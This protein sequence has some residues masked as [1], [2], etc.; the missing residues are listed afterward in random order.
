MAKALICD[1]CK[2][3]ITRYGQMNT[4]K[5]MPYIGIEAVNQSNSKSVDLCNECTK[6]LMQYINNE[7]EMVIFN[8]RRAEDDKTEHSDPGI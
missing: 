6:T 5:I 2:A 1:R 7:V 4:I 8:D 3:V